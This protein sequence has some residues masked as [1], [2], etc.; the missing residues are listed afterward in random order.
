[1]SKKKKII[2]ETSIL[3]IILVIDQLTK[4]LMINQNIFVIPEILNFS[5]TQNTGVAFSIGENNTILIILLNLLILGLIVKS[6]KD[7]ELDLKVSISLFMILAGGV[8]NVIDRIFRGY[9]I[10]F[11]DVNIFNFPKF[12]IADISIVLGVGILVIYVIIKQFAKE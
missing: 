11:I 4:M 7:N 6:I 1:M 10:D 8:S 3:L 12:N 9:V 5:Y 2:I